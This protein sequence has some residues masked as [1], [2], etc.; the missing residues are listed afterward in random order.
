[1]ARFL[2]R[3]F[4]QRLSLRVKRRREMLMS[5]IVAVALGLAPTQQAGNQFVSGDYSKQVGQFSQYVDRRG[6]T[7]VSGHD[8]W[9]VPYELVMDRNGYVE[10]SV[11]SSWIVQFQVKEAA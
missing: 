9:G 6:T 3:L 1:L 2:I 10:A 8:H 5:T 7:H 4:P 11:G